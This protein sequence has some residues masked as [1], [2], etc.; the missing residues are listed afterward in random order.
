L[1]FFR[2]STS[3]NASV[4]ACFSRLALAISRSNSTIPAS[5]RCAQRTRPVGDR[6]GVRS[7]GAVLASLG[8]RVAGIRSAVAGLRRLVVSFGTLVAT[9]RDP[10]SVLPMAVARLNAG[11]VIAQHLHHGTLLDA[12]DTCHA[13]PGRE[14]RPLP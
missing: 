14:L 1:V 6:S 8:T 12:S 5:L 11:S 9:F 3:T 13:A 2:S 4:N 10:V 7:A